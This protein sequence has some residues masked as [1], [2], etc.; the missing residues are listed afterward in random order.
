MIRIS[1][2]QMFS[3]I[4]L[5]QFGTTIIFGFASA[6]GRDAWIASFGS[7]LTGMLLIGLY[8]MIQRLQPEFSL[9]EW[10]S[11]QFGSWLGTPIAW[12][13]PLIFIYDAGRVLAD[14]R[15]LIPQTIL[16]NTPSW[17]ILIS[18]MLVV[19]YVLFSGIEVICRLAGV[20]LPIIMIIFMIELVL[21]LVSKSVHPSYLTPILGEGVGRVWNAVWTLGMTQTYGES[22]EFFVFWVLV[23]ERRNMTAVNMWAALIAGSVIAVFELLAI[24]GMGEEL[25]VRNNFPTFVLLKLVSVGGFLEN[26]DALGVMYFMITTFFKASLHLLAAIYC[27]QKLTRIKKQSWIILTASALSM[28]LGMSMAESFP[29]HVKAG[30]VMLPLYVWV[31]LFIVFPILLLIVSWIRKA[32]RGSGPGAS[33]QPDK[34]I[35]RGSEPS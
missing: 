35:Q 18:F 13:Y 9:V 4:V 5:F 32:S 15:F 16:P 20:L 22:I 21:L 34:V 10:F 2:Y 11:N 19:L 7:T 8:S 23:N 14:L 25:F 1:R 28:Y 24:M 27:I 6:A 33:T 12:M 17:V 3:S 29:E 30:L 31:P 26:L